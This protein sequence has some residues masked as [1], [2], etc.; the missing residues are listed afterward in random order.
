MIQ[1]PRFLRSTLLLLISFVLSVIVSWLAA[2]IVFFG[3]LEGD[4]DL[5]YIF[6]YFFLAISGK[7]FEKVGLIFLI[8]AAFFLVLFPTTYYLLT[9]KLRC[10]L[11]R[12]KGPIVPE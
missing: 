7:G 1:L 12:E 8:S 5:S 11:Q 2:Y 10:R 3:I 9:R 4:L 6:E